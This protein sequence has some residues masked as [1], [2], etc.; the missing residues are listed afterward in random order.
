MA[1]RLDEA[2]EQGAVATQ[3]DLAQALEVAR[4]NATRH[5]ARVSFF[6]SDLLE[7]I[8]EATLEPLQQGALE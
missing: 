2:V 7:A 6:Q 3:E 4:E 1:W 5:E 8:D